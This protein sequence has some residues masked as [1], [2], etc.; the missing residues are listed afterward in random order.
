MSDRVPVRV[1]QDPFQDDWGV[2]R[3]EP[4]VEENFVILTSRVEINGFQQ[5]RYLEKNWSKLCTRN[6]RIIILTGIHGNKDGSVRKDKD[7]TYFV[8]FLKNMNHFLKINTYAD[9][10]KANEAKLMVIDLGEYMTA[11]D[12]VDEE[13]LI[14]DMNEFRPTRI[15]LAFC[16]TNASQLNDL[17]RSAGIYSFMLLGEDRAKLTGGKC[18]VLDAGQGNVL[19]TVSESD[20]RNVLLWGSSGTGKT[21]LLCEVLKIQVSKLKRKGKKVKIFATTWSYADHLTE[22]LRDQYLAGV[23]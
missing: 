16:N 10:L 21:L 17:F 7:E 12:K 22:K 8:Y 11:V 15:V 6:A 23:K 5:R 18:Y 2:E 14:Q 19:K 20:I 3:L 4:F 9:D 1:Q 13:K